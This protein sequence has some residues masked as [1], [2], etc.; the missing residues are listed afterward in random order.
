[1][2]QLQFDDDAGNILLQVGRKE[3]IM[4]FLIFLLHFLFWTAV[5]LCALCAALVLT[6]VIAMVVGGIRYIRE[7][8]RELREEKADDEQR[9]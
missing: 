3:R 6:V 8:N 4:D 7:R 1:M 2:H 9:L 5:F